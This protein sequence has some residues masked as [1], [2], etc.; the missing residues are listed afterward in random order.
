MLSPWERRHLP[1][2]RHAAERLGAAEQVGHCCGELTECRCCRRGPRPEDEVDPGPDRQLPAD[3]AKATTDAIAN[4][5]IADPL[6][7]DYREAKRVQP[8]RSKTNGDQR[9]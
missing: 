2:R 5:G 1:V 4:H 8:V 7:G 6:A 9:A 3:L